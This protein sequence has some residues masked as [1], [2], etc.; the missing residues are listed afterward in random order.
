MDQ[1]KKELDYLE[2]TKRKEISKAIKHT[3]AFGDLKENAAY[4]EAKDAQGFLE[5]KIREL[6][7]LISQAKVA[8]KKENDKVQ[9][10]SLVALIS[11]KE[12][13]EI[14]IV[15]P[16]EANPFKGKISHKS[17]LGEALLGKKKDDTVKFKT[18]ENENEYKILEI[19]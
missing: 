16:E 4:Q 10:G 13:M 1:F 9:I 18:V 7:D 3:A 8:D 12:K 6:K 17:S 14:Q 15:E 11:G 2:N 5:R 19:K